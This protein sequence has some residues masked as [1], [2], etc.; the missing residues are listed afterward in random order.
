MPETESEV[1]SEL[2]GIFREVFDDDALV[3][4]SSTT[5]EDIPLWDSLHHI[6]LIMAVE[7]HFGIKFRTGEIEK[8]TNV[9]D[10]VA[11]VVKKS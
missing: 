10:L 2:S 4:T 3:I 5:A 6:N 9:G 7:G 8:M 11:G 1:L